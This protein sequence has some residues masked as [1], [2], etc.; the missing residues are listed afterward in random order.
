M[1]PIDTL[2]PRLLRSYSRTSTNAARHTDGCV[3][4]EATVEQPEL[5]RSYLDAFGAEQV[6]DS[7]ALRAVQQLVGTPPP[8]TRGP[9][10]VEPGADVGR[11]AVRLED[12]GDA[13]VD[14]V[15]PSDFPVGYHRI[16]DD[17]GERALI[18]TPGVCHLP[19]D[20]RAWGWAVQLYAARSRRSWGMGDL[21]DLAQIGQWSAA[22]GAG[23]LLVNPLHAAAPVG[24]QEASPYSPSSRRFSNPIYLDIDAVAAS[25][26]PSVVSATLPQLAEQG[27]ALNG[28]RII[29]RDHVMRLKMEALEGMWAGLEQLP[30]A[31]SEFDAWF[32]DSP[33]SLREY[34]TWCALAEGFGSDWRTWPAQYRRNSNSDVDSFAAQHPSR[35]RFHAWQQWLAQQQLQH[36]QSTIGIVQDLPIGFGPG[37][38]DAWC[39][40]DLI[41]QDAS[42][43]APPDELNTSGQNWGLPPFVPWKLALADYGPFIETVRATIAAEGGLRI[44]HVMG[45]FR[46]WWIPEGSGSGGGAYVRYPSDDLLGIIALESQRQRAVVV[47]EDLGTVEPGVREQLASRHVLSYRLLW[48]EEDE[49]STWPRSAMAA[50]STHD[51]PTVTGMWTG[52]D[53]QALQELDMGSDDDTAD[54]TRERMTEHAGLAADASAGEA[55]AA[56]YQLLAAA[57]SVML[58]ATLDDAFL[59]AERPNIPGAP[60]ERPNWS[61]ALPDT[62]EALQTNPIAAGIARSFNDAIHAVSTGQEPSSC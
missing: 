55:V 51:L 13:E 32:A 44:D 62:I 46:L 21:G 49:P 12:G 23:F 43:G 36:A 7:A 28:D 18:V 20:W 5:E 54:A 35:I 14:G 31:L 6:I 22:D 16:T 52:Q 30:A 26:P 39:W 33:T 27:R 19:D 34:A 15:L 10:V 42:V 59:E 56:A 40:Q 50:I 9:S 24:V 60:P 37:G 4:V 48:F 61:I 29:D 17:A 41:A 58:C 8:S 3:R 25:L 11:G 2:I 45:L 38:A 1:R 53:Q 47:G 57:P